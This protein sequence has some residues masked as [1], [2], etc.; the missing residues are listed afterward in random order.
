MK[1]KKIALIA[2]IV[3]VLA[4]IVGFTVTQSQ[5]NLVAVQTTKA[6]TG[7]ISSVVT[8]SGQIKPLTYVNIGANA[9]GQITHLYVKEGERVKKG[10]IVAQLDN[11]Q[12]A[13][14]LAASRANLQIATTDAAA[15]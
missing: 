9:M 15:A 5:K 14:G 1:A 11:V 8:A 3:V 12:P 4:A 7:D 13:A 2:G 6:A 10:Q